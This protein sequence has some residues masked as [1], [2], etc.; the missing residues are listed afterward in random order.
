[1]KHTAE[2]MLQFEIERYDSLPA[3]LDGLIRCT[4]DQFHRLISVAD[5]DVDV[6]GHVDEI[7]MS[8]LMESE[9]GESEKWGV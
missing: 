6:D 3:V 4:Q 1:M 5:M 2:T 9:R 8:G 7:G